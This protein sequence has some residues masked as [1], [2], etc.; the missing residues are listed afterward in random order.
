MVNE[1]I[2]EIAA[3]YGDNIISTQ[4]V[5]PDNVHPSWRGYKELVKKAGL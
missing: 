1:N 5:Q 3:K 4:F 2:K